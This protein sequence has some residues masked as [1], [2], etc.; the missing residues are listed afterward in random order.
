M[1]SFRLYNRFFAFWKDYGKTASHP[2]P[3]VYADI[4]VM[5]PYNLPDHGQAQAKTGT[6][7]SGAVYLVKTLPDFLLVFRGN[8]DAVVL[9]FQYEIIPAVMEF[10][11]DAAIILTVFAGILQQVHDGPGEEM[12]IC[13]GVK[14][15]LYVPFQGNASGEM[16][17]RDRIFCVRLL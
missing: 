7:L 9:H 1:I 4:P 6:S 16:C 15:F 10:Y 14:M 3:A 8:P 11:S 17:I 13:L 12:G 2:G 5:E